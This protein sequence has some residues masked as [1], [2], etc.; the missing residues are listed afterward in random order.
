LEK[1]YPLLEM[2]GKMQDFSEALEGLSFPQDGYSLMLFEHIVSGGKK[3][4]PDYKDFNGD[5]DRLLV[6]C[7]QSGYK[8]MFRD[9]D[10]HSEKMEFTP[11]LILACAKAEERELSIKERIE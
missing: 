8:W 10:Y 1:K 7:K 4:H 6:L 9:D 5:F 3:Y 2:M 11:E